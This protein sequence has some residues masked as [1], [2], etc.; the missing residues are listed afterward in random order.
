MNAADCAAARARLTALKDY[1]DPYH[2]PRYSYH[3]K[4]NRMLDCLERKLFSAPK[5]GAEDAFRRYVKSVEN[6]SRSNHVMRLQLYYDTAY[7]ALG[8]ADVEFT[9]YILKN[10]P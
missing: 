5:P 8:M 9:T 2:E 4:G 7:M 1:P 6:T 10:Y 3:A